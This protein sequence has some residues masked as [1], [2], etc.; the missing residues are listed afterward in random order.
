MVSAGAEWSLRVSRRRTLKNIEPTRIGRAFGEGQ[1]IP[2]LSS[3]SN[4]SGGP[5]RVHAATLRAARRRGLDLGDAT[6]APGNVND[7]V[8][9]HAQDW[10][11]D[12][13]AMVSRGRDHLV[14]MFLGSTLDQILN[15]SPCPVLAVPA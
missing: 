9:G 14:D 12:L 7:A 11:A 10:N 6:V 8:I 4:L 13:I 3:A 1:G 15:S 2:A 5:R